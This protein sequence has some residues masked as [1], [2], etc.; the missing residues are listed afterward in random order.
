M[1]AA[2]GRTPIKC[3][4]CGENNEGAMQFCIFCGATLMLP[5]PSPKPDEVSQSSIATVPNFPAANN[6]LVCTICHR[7]DPLHGQYCVFCGGR[8]T[9]HAQQV[10]SS[11][12]LPAA[13]HSRMPAMERS[14]NQ[15]P[16]GEFPSVHGNNVSHP[17]K[18]A[19]GGGVVGIVLAILLGGILGGGAGFGAVFAFK[20]SLEPG[21]LEK[22]WPGD[23]LV[24]YTAVPG[25]NVMVENHDEKS[26]FTGMTGKTGSLA[27]DSIAAGSYRVSLLDGSRAVRKNVVV[28]SGSVAVVGYPDPVK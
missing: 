14:S 16:S 27:I 28:N 1:T 3:T 22:Q 10:D 8:T 9:T 12:R 24:V 7:S 18:G 20:G 23:G 15:H 5:Q 26:I 21:I 11:S 6:A 19:S 25:S 13:T 4:T 17:R 2:P